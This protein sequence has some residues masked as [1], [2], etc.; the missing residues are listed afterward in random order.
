MGLNY[1][2]SD[3]NIQPD[4]NEHGGSIMIEKVLIFGKDT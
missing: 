3:D 4:S 1:V 2:L